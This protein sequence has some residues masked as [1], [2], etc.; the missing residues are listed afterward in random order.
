MGDSLCGPELLRLL[1]AGG[2]LTEHVF[3]NR[4][5]QPLTSFGIHTLVK[6]Y[7]RR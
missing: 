1:I 3:L 4:R 2:A 7:V 5:G 6:R